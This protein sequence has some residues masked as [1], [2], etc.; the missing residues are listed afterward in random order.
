MIISVMFDKEEIGCWQRI[1]SKTLYVL[2][3]KCTN[4]YSDNATRIII[5]TTVDNT[6]CL[7]ELVTFLG[8][9]TRSDVRTSAL[10]WIEGLSS[11]STGVTIFKADN[12]L[13][14]RRLLALLFHRSSSSTTNDEV[15]IVL[16]IFVNLTADCDDCANYLMQKDDDDDKKKDDDLVRILCLL[17]SRRI[18]GGGGGDAVELSSAKL[19]AN[20]SRHNAS[21]MCVRI[22]RHWPHFVADTIGLCIR[23]KTMC[24]I[25]V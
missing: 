11:S 5:M 21:I 10:S 19:L 4:F 6:E 17:S 13:L 24:L 18:E 3:R 2:I 12:Y 1:Y 7:S 15:L 9:D 16:N 14:C 23:I 8:V 22:V 25:I 20:L